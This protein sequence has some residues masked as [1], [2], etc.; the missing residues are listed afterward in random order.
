MTDETAVQDHYQVDGLLDVIREGLANMGVAVDKVSQADLT[1]IDEFHIGGRPATAAFAERLAPAAGEHLLDIGCGI[2]GSTRFIAEAY[3]CRVSGID[4]TPAF[5][6][7]ARELAD[8]VGLGDR[9]DFEQASA[10]DLPFEDGYFDGAFTIHVA[11]NIADKAAMYGEVRRVLKPAGRFGIY[12]VMALDERGPIFPAPWAEDAG[13]SA[14]ESPEAVMALLRAAGFEVLEMRNRRRFGIEF[15]AEMRG[16]AAGGAPPPLTVQALM[17][18]NA[19]DKLAN[20]A[21]ALGE[22]RLA[23]VEM[24]CRR[25]D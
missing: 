18:A 23:P 9:V 15:F 7:T 8:W 22:G 12:D 10:L 20:I 5:C 3:D 17:G 25:L 16:Q 2:G 21:R 14:V 11:M 24:I 6:E 19:M 13:T 1:G 4:L